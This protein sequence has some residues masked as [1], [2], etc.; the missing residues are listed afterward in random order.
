VGFYLF[1]SYRSRCIGNFPCCDL[2]N[3]IMLTYALYITLNC[4]DRTR[5]ELACCVA[6]WHVVLPIGM[7]CCLLAC[8]VA[9]WHVLLPTGMLCCLLACCITYWHVVL[10]V[11][12]LC[13][14]LVCCVACWHVVLPTGML[15]YLFLIMGLPVKC[16]SCY[17]VY[18]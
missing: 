4:C 5:I 18:V 1:L 16:I 3:S 2:T 8:C 13:C 15:C 6:Y 12:M 17:K 10:P 11:G 14:L 9:Y 7:L